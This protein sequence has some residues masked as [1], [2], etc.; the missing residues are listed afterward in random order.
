MTP[1]TKSDILALPPDEQTS[2]MQRLAASILVRLP[3]GTVVEDASTIERFGF[4]REDFTDPLPEPPLIVAQEHSAEQEATVVDTPTPIALGAA[5]V[6]SAGYGADE[7]VI[8]LNKLLKVK[9]ANELATHP[10]LVATYTWLETVQAMAVA[11]QTAFPPA[12][13]TFEEV[14]SE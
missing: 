1:N 2:W 12:P 8:C 9:D 5:W 3:D 10:K 4:D 7:K 14:V 6:R 11:G 13:H